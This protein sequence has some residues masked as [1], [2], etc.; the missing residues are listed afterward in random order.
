MSFSPLVHHEYVLSSGLRLVVVPM[1]STKTATVLVSV[2]TGTKNET[3]E[4]NG[5]S[6]FLEHMFFKGTSKRPTS[7]DIAKEL[8]GLGADYNGYTLKEST[9]YYAKVSADKLE[10]A[11]DIISDIFQNSTLEEDSLNIERGVILEEINMYLDQPSSMVG[12]ELER[13]LY[14]DQPAGW[15]ILGTPEIISKLTRDQFVEYFS[16]HY[17]ARNSVVAVAGN[18]D[19]ESTRKMIEK[20]F[21]NP[22]TSNPV[23]RLPVAENQS[24]PASLI[25]YKKTD[26]THF[27]LGF[28]AF[29]ARD[30]RRYPTAVLSAI[31]G[32]GMSSRLPQE[33]RTKKGLA[34]YAYSSHSKYSDSGYFEIGAGVN[35]SKAVEAVSAALEEVRKIRDGRIEEEEIKRG[36]DQIVGRVQIGL[37]HSDAIADSYSSSILIHGRVLTPEETLDRIKKVTLEQVISVAKELFVPE[38]MNL[39]VVGPFEDP[40]SFNKILTL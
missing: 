40:I 38:K 28:R 36:I 18:V 22:R 35:N 13:L 15:P 20:Y 4:I 16:T 25:S 21:D 30:D 3:K 11:V 1:P 32:G 24:S 19:P 39:A 29:G 5:I 31:L 27:I 9:D 8:D 26:Q 14:G 7:L 10:I 23:A 2:G 34:Y 12:V 6:H 17:V 37:E 33:L